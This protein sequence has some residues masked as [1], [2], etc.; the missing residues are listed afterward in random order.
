MT[1]RKMRTDARSE[2]LMRLVQ[3]KPCDRQ[4]Q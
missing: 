2:R 4:M 3:E 1:D